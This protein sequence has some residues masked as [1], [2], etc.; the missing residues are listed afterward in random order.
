MLN[1][2]THCWI[3][4]IQNKLVLA[5]SHG[6]RLDSCGRINPI[7]DKLGKCRKFIHKFKNYIVATTVESSEGFIRK[8]V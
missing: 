4:T 8:S 6:K 1:G 5:Y 7:P 3:D 2:S